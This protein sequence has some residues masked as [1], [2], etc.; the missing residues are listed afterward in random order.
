MP[1]KKGNKYAL[2]NNGGRP[3]IVPE[4]DRPALFAEMLKDFQ[5]HLDNL[6]KESGLIFIENWCRK[7]GISDQTLHNYSEA[8]EEFLA[9]IK[10]C[11]QIQKEVLIQGAIRGYFNPTAFIFTAKNITDMRDKIETDLTSDGKAINFGWQKEN[12]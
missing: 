8:N 9:C 2:G 7:H 5:E 3:V 12:T 6:N 10:A 11:K 1:A 4:K